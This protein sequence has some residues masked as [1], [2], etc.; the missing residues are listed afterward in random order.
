VHR[1]LISTALALAIPALAW[2][3][4]ET[5]APPL[6]L[7]DAAAIAAELQSAAAQGIAAPDVSGDVSSLVDPD[8]AARTAA[9]QH[10]IRAAVA[11]AGAE[12]GMD[13]D[14]H[15]IDPNF[16][17]RAPYNAQ[18]EFDQ[19]RAQG[20]IGAWLDAQNRKDPAY[21]ALLA[22]RARYAALAASGWP[23]QVA[24]GA[25]LKVGMRDA[26]VPALVQRLAAEGYAP[27]P[28][29]PA[30]AANATGGAAADADP[31]LYDPTIAA[32]VSDYQS[33][34]A[35][36]ATGVLDEATVAALAI[37]PAERLKAIDVN[38]ERAR[39][40]P[41][42]MPA[43][44]IEADIG[45][46]IVTLFQDD[47]A[48]LTMRA[49]A[50][51]PRKQTP[52]FASDVI[53]VVFNP[54]WYVPADI[55]RKELFPHE[56]RSPGY[57]ARNQMIVSNGSVIQ[58]AGPFSAL[59]YVKFD[60]PDPYAV[61]LHDTPSRGAFASNERWRSHGCVRLQMPR[62]LAAA[63]LSPQG[64]TP[65]TIDKAIADKA[66]RRVPLT[67]KTPV[68]VLYRTAEVSDDGKVEFRQDVYGWDAELAAAMA[69]HPLPVHHAAATVAAP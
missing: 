68:F 65:A 20:Q 47:K 56:A 62:E 39:W 9:E 22:A 40:L 32:A 25:P 59:G 24:G 44:R 67:T 54:P 51:A 63:L 42:A 28:P 4:T 10:L 64:W 36:D 43:N 49:V 26:R 29:A 7:A 45:G 35:I 66:T 23:A 17:L 18:A 57:F 50:G 12:H 1:L 27:T 46:P 55:A 8:P 60:V 3:K 6:S 61:Y 52:S 5:P 16:N 38:L 15:A 14:P 30:A 31:L 69:G 13:L 33:H 11:F 37:S 21:L 58:K 19:A 34:H 53:A 48:A 41:V 2:A